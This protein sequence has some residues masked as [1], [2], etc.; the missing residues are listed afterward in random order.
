VFVKSAKSS[1]RSEASANRSVL[2]YDPTKLWMSFGFLVTAYS[3]GQPPT[4][5][6]GLKQ[7][8]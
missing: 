5:S 1:I 8:R 3:R 7:S 6:P 4:C 2:A